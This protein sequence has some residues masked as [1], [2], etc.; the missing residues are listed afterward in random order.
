ME[1]MIETETTSKSG[2]P[3]AK[4]FKLVL[5]V[6]SGRTHRPVTLFNHNHDGRWSGEIGGG[7]SATVT[8]D[9]AG[10]WSLTINRGRESLTFFPVSVSR[11]WE[12]CFRL[13]A[14]WVSASVC[15]VYASAA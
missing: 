10:K 12:L 11:P 5:Y 1:S 2:E 7:K 3:V 15:E 4:S 8:R 14:G 13:P 9:V 6:P